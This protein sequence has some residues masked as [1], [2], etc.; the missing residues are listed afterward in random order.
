MTSHVLHRGA[1]IAVRAL[2]LTRPLFLFD[3]C[4]GSGSKPSKSAYHSLVQLVLPTLVVLVGYLISLAFAG[5]MRQLCLLCFAIQFAAWI[6]SAYFQ[7]EKV[8]LG[9]PCASICLLLQSEPSHSWCGRVQ[10]YDLTGAATYLSLTV[11][12]VTSVPQL[13][14]RQTINRCS[15]NWQSQCSP[16]SLL[17]RSSRVY[18][19]CW[20]AQCAGG[21]VG[22]PAG[23]VPLYARAAGRLR[24]SLR[25][26]ESSLLCC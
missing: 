24:R 2:W 9:T 5:P 6:P 21:G 7:S 1:S 11:L 18:L 4:P 17:L 12:S 22:G 26:S 19:L 8:R 10:C 23:H 15:L 13:S 25:E 20:C 16:V 14:A 3:R